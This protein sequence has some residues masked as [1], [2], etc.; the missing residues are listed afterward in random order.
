MFEKGRFVAKVPK[1]RVDA[2]VSSGNG[3]YFDPG[4]GRLI[5]D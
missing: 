3:E 1:E 2:L 5:K 4:H